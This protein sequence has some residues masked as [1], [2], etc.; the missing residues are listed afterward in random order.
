MTPV[1]DH[2]A[3]FS[4]ALIPIFARIVDEHRPRR[5][6]PLQVLDPFAGVGGIHVLM[7]RCDL[8]VETVGVELLARWAA[9]HP[10]TIVG[11]ARALPF[12]RGAVDVVVTS[13]C[14]GN[15]MAD[16]HNNRDACRC[17]K[18][19]RGLVVSSVG[20]RDCKACRG[21]GISHRRSYFHYHGAEGWIADDNAG[22]MQWGD[23]YRELHEA[24]WREVHRVLPRR[25]LFVLNIKDHQR[26]GVWQRV[27]QWHRRTITRLGFTQVERW[28]VPLTGYRNGSHRD[29]RSGVEYVYVFQR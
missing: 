11:N 21:T 16:K 4:A 2:P 13:P 10:R 25:G 22:A 15:R 5:R 19:K 14:Y 6:R 20:R 26:D 27:P 9:A 18:N 28:T 1:P 8:P 7:E 17:R 12:G 23:E 3:E 24:V 29:A